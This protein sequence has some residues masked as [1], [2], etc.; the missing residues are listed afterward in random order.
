M[1]ELHRLFRSLSSS[2]SFFTKQRQK[3]AINFEGQRIITYL[4]P[5]N[6]SRYSQSHFRNWYT[7]LDLALGVWYYANTAINRTNLT[8]WTSF[9][10]DNKC[11][12]PI[13]RRKVAT[14]RLV[15]VMKFMKH[16]FFYVT[17]LI[18]KRLSN[19]FSPKAQPIKYWYMDL[20]RIAI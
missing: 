13:S 1:R 15:N 14:Y 16:F 12:I 3:K 2:S 18:S 19:H 20:K 7:C 5:N 6:L 17:S 11:N 10:I 9:I 4:I 8:N